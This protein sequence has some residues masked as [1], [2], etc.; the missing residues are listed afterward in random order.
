MGRPACSARIRSAKRMITC[1]LCSIIT[2]VSPRCLS[3][4][5]SVISPAM[6]RWSTP[7]VTSSMRISRG[8]VASPRAS[9]S[10]L[11]C[12][13]ESSRAKSLR[14]SSRLTKA[15]DSSARSRA[16]FRS[17]VWAS[18]PTMTFSVTVRSRKGFS[19]W[20][21]R[22]TPRWLMR[23]GRRPVMS[24]PSR[25]TRPA[26]GGWKPVIRSNSVDLPAPLGPMMPTISPSFT[27]KTTLALAVSP[28]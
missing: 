13:V 4:S 28:P 12:P 26:S 22:A 18:A 14:F 21:V 8:P 9:S 16:V 10:R 17:D 6:E 27:S 24:C 3:S 25:R 2:M 15:S 19:F 20:K 1:M 11:R 23:S 5:T 7:P